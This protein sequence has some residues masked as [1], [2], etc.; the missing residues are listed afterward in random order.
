MTI[1]NLLL[2]STEGVVIQKRLALDFRCWW[3]CCCLNMEYFTQKTLL[4]YASTRS[5][6]L[7]SKFKIHTHLWTAWIIPS[8]F[9]NKV[10][11]IRTPELSKRFLRHWFLWSWN[12]ALRTT[13][14]VY[15]WETAKKSKFWCNNAFRYSSVSSRFLYTQKYSLM[16]I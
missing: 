2:N 9:V 13:H 16:L 12:L 4:R 5:V 1:G 15:L 10:T 14:R 6:R 8:F 3:D 11:N 7:G